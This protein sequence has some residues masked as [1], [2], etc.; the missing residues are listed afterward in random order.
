[1]NGI[2]SRGFVVIFFLITALVSGLLRWSDVI[3]AGV[4]TRWLLLIHVVSGLAGLAILPFWLKAHVGKHRRASASRRS[5]TGF[6]LSGA[7]L[8]AGASGVFLALSF[9]LYL[10]KVHW[11]P[12]WYTEGAGAYTAI[13]WG[14][15]VHLLATLGIVAFLGHLGI[16]WGRARS[17][18]WR[19]LAAGTVLSIMVA[20]ALAAGFRPHAEA[21]VPVDRVPYYSLPWGANP[22]RPGNLA[23]V[24]GRFVDPERIPAARTCAGCHQR[25]TREWGASLHSVTGPDRIYETAIRLNEKIAIR[26][27]GT[28]KIR[29]CDACHEPGRLLTGSIN[30]I[31]TV[32][33]SEAAAEGT[34]CVICHTAVKATDEGNGSLTV[35]L[36][37]VETD[38]ATIV[39]SPEEHAGDMG[40]PFFRDTL[41]RPELCGACHNEFRPTE[42][43]PEIPLQETFKQWAESEYKDRGITCVDCHMNQDPAGFIKKLGE[44]GHVPPRGRLSH[45][46]VGPNTLLAD[47]D[48][49]LLTF[50]RGGSAPAGL[51]EQAWRE[52]LRI[53][54]RLGEELLRA[55]ARL[56]I[57]EPDMRA[58]AAASVLVEVTNEG[59]GHDLPTGALD[60]KHM[61]LELKVAAADGRVVFQSGWFDASTGKLDPETVLYSKRIYDK[62]GQPL[63]RHELFPI[64][65]MEWTR[66]P[67]PPGKTDRVPFRFEVPPDTRGPLTITARLWYRA[68]FQD[69]VAYNLKVSQ[70]VQPVLMAETSVLLSAGVVQARVCDGG[71]GSWSPWMAGRAVRQAMLGAQAALQSGDRAGAA[72]SV[73]EAAG[74]YRA[75][76]AAPFQAVAPRLAGDLAGE[77]AA[78]RSAAA[79]GDELRLSFSRGLAWG[80]VLEGA[81]RQGLARL[82]AG[83]FQ[84]AEEW[85]RLREHPE[86]TAQGPLDDPVEETLS[87]LR[88]KGSGQG[89]DA[90]TTIRHEMNRVYLARLHRS[91]DESTLAGKRGFLAQQAFWAGSA[92]GYYRILAPDIEQSLGAGEAREIDAAFSEM[93]SLAWQG[94]DPAG[95]LAAIQERLRLYSPVR[96]DE[97][98]VAER[99]GLLFT[100][101][102]LIVVEYRDAGVSGGRIRVPI[103]YQEA[104][105]F[106]REARGII[107]ELYPHLH[108]K[109]RAEAVALIEQA[110]GIET[111]IRDKSP[112]DR[113]AAEVE[114]LREKVAGVSGVTAGAT[115]GG[116]EIL[117]VVSRNLARITELVASGDY[118]EAERLR[119]ESYALFESGPEAT[120]RNREPG[121]AARLEGLFWEGWGEQP[122]L[123]RLLDRRAGGDEVVRTVTEMNTALAG[124]ERVMAGPQT[125]VAAAIQSMSIIVREG[126]EA[127][128]ILAAVL[129]YLAK[130]GQA[131]LR[132]QLYVGVVLALVGSVATWWLSR[133]VIEISGAGRELIEGITGLLAVAV[134][135]MVVNWLFKKAYVDDWLAEIKTRARMAIRLES[136]LTMA[137]LGFVVVYREGFET[138]LFYQALLTG[139]NFGPV[140]M[141]FVGGLMLVLAVAYPLLV[142]GRRIPLRPFF[143]ITGVLLLLLAFKFM[144]SGLRELQEAGVLRSTPM[145]SIPASFWMQEI[146]GIFSTVETS[147]G[148][149]LLLLAFLLSWVTARVRVGMTN[150]EPID[151]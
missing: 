17:A 47:P 63:V 116:A 8:V 150:Q 21:S 33:P 93:A 97:D 92:L 74:L 133:A 64:A 151:H 109:D 76:F 53:Q 16:S 67:I 85:L 84:E 49:P 41:R 18:A 19:S 81:F 96:W 144:G 57:V 55:A 120:L 50:L 45:R 3:G 26:D 142:L 127:V 95:S 106:A 46:F 62:D 107:T 80:M 69:L 89:E 2:G 143:K 79:A 13:H 147:L 72:A 10:F 119:M 128:L 77:L 138:V 111:L 51:D 1:M 30:P 20:L 100:Y 103:E 124:A 134:L 24:D 91:L 61:W 129:G 59:A 29:W 12:R 146:A 15:T 104:V 52:D 58:G 88:T 105:S 132:R 36:R 25:E 145:P 125:A 115:R 148:Q 44:N 4:A 117:S 60:Q 32:K 14:K 65:R 112:L 68:A 99:I 48:N 38:P 40:S 73:E 75:V 66:Q 39:L 122:G 6:A 27:L 43:N 37:H 23:T 108:R 35:D 56:Q 71:D 118:G 113:V 78:A 86:R 139:T 11:F 110:A 5:G 31:V 90:V 82:E 54:K 137:G 101:L 7:L 135:F 9:F 123:L 141:G 70:I 42:V 140:M 98:R 126:L 28:E 131:R 149:I 34:S 121:L 114:R 22:F 130:T 87:A 136:P 94:Q 102:D 83:A